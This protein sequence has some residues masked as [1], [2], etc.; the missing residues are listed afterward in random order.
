M[1]NVSIHCA[2]DAV[3]LTEDIKPNPKNPNTHPDSQIELLA[4]IIREQGWRAPVTVSTRSGMVVRGHG[5]LLAAAKLGLDSVPVDYQDYG[6]DESE[7]ADLVAD[8]R[9]SDLS[10]FGEEALAMLLSGVDV[11]LAGF[12]DVDARKM[13]SHIELDDL[14]G[15]ADPKPHNDTCKCPKCGFEFEP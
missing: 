14:D 4:K 11:E 7:T 5:R 15:N 3:V 10:L 12:T 6:S 9:L 13:L 2:H 8:N 1:I